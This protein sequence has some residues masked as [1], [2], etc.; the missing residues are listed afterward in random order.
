M[1][2]N[3]FSCHRFLVEHMHAMAHWDRA[4]EYDHCYGYSSDR[5][6]HISNA[7][8]DIISSHCPLSKTSPRG[9]WYVSRFAG[10][11]NPWISVV[12]KLPNRLIAGL[13]IHWNSK[14]ALDRIHSIVTDRSPSRITVDDRQRSLYLLCGHE[15]RE[16]ASAILVGRTSSWAE[17]EI[18]FVQEKLDPL[19]ATAV[20]SIKLHL[21]C[22]RYLRAR[23]KLAG[24]VWWTTGGVCG[25]VRETEGCK[26]WKAC[27]TIMVMSLWD[28]RSQIGDL[29]R[30]IVVSWAKLSDM[31]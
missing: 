25:V 26:A 27:E 30:S 1:R 8:A 17:I 2:L 11:L 13:S 4:S 23:A 14:I 28:R 21:R 29:P 5:V 10:E 7:S 9:R 3:L 12:G 24:G 18:R 20:E 6:V 15:S 16:A 22:E 19:L 31:L